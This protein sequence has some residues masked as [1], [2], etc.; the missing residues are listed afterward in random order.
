MRLVLGKSKIALGTGTGTSTGRKKI[1]CLLKNFS[2]IG[3]E[4]VIEREIAVLVNCRWNKT[5][6][7]SDIRTFLYKLYHNIL[8]LNVR[9]HHINPE[10]DMACTFCLKTNNLPAERESFVHFFWYCPTVNGI[11]TDFFGR[12]IAFTVTKRNYFFGTSG[13]DNFCEP[14]AVVFDI[15]K[16][17]FWQLRIRRRLPNRHNV[18]SEFNYILG[19][20]MNGNKKLKGQ[21]N[22]CNLFRRN[23]DGQG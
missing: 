22:S 21:I 11:L 6:F 20:T 15:L 12:H 5:Y 23:G 17:V 7:N 14:V 18:E 9:I 10:R 2:I 16:F 3:E 19:L 13:D 4:P 1:S 8:G